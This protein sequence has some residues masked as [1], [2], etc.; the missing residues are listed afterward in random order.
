MAS[1]SLTLQG[2]HYTIK[3]LQLVVRDAAVVPAEIKPFVGI[4]YH[5]STDVYQ[6]FQHLAS[7]PVEFFLVLHLDN[8]N[9]VVGMTTASIGSMT[10]SIVHPRD[11]FRPAIV[12]LT[13]SVVFV[14]NHP[15]GDP[16]PSREDIEITSRLQ[17][18]G[19]LI[20]IRCLDHI[21]IGNTRYFSFA[22]EGMMR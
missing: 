5:S 22:D 8:K 17:E 12:N 7:M 20:G 6:S 18:V 13:S 2:N 9:R 16:S 19:K 1:T 14:H 10:A 21:I 3:E 11:I 4:R 15:S